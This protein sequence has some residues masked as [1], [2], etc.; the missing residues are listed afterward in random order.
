MDPQVCPFIFI[1]DMCSLPLQGNIRAFGDN[2]TNADHNEAPP[3]VKTNT[4]ASKPADG[5]ASAPAAVDGIDIRDPRVLAN[6]RLRK[7]LLF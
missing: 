2:I 7:F 5:N 1:F 3:V 4:T 6:I